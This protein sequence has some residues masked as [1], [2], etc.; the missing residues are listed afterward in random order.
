[1]GLPA[2]LWLLGALL[3]EQ[4]HIPL[5]IMEDLAAEFWDEFR[6][7][8]EWQQGLLQS[9]ER[10]GYVE[11]LDGRRRRG[12]MTL[13]QIINHPIQGTAF[14]IV[15]AGM[16]A[17]SE[18]A[19]A[20]DNWSGTRGSTAT[21]TSPSSWGQEPGVENIEV[22]ARRCASRGSTLSTCRSSSRSASGT[23]WNELEEIRKYSSEQ[24][25]NIPNPYREA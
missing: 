24:L 15:C 7:V 5:D 13:N 17:L 9:Y 8:K 21:T 1:V 19:D 16:N 18:R 10:K 2:A 25:F 14:S 23:R 20:E 3:R 6:G 22:I 12:P 4:L 11:T